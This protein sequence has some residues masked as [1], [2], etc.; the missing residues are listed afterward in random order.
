[1]TASER[2]SPEPAMICDSPG[3]AVRKRS[4]WQRFSAETRNSINQ[5]LFAGGM[6]QESIALYSRWWQ[7]ET[8]L[9]SLLYVELRSAYGVDWS[10]HIGQGATSRQQMDEARK[11]MATA[12]WEDPLSYLDIGKLFPR[13]EEHWDLVA[14][15][16]MDKETF[17]ARKPELMAIRNRLGHLRRPHEDDL[18]RLQQTLRDLEKGAFTAYSSYNAYQRIDRETS[19]PVVD[20]WIHEE[21][22]TA[23]RLINHARQQYEVGFNLYHS[24][25]PYAQPPSPG[26]PVTGNPGSVWLATFNTITRDVDPAVLW[27]DSYLNKNSRELLIH[28]LVDYGSVTFTFPAVDDGARVADAIGESFD[29]VL[30][31]LRS[32]NELSDLDVSE[33]PLRDIRLDPRIQIASGWNIVD[34]STVPITIFSA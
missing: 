4:T 3:G 10:N 9:R 22:R 26:S 7:L 25:R 20:A 6:P 23:Q 12:D 33:T 2:Y 18:G 28:M 17:L 13:L 31:S 27:R 29:A 11:Y 15:S 32:R 14:P 8:Y 30:L 1:M 16:L 21:H 19:D 5:A 24:L 34:E